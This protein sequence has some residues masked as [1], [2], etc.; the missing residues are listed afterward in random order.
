VARA[1]RAEQ[2]LRQICIETSSPAGNLLGCLS[3]VSK[4][5]RAALAGSPDTAESCAPDCCPD[6]WAC[7]GVAPTETDGASDGAAE[8]IRDWIEWANDAAST[9]GDSDTGPVI[10]ALDELVAALER[11]EQRAARA[12]HFIEC[13]D[14][15]LMRDV[16]AKRDEAV[17]RAERA[18]QAIREHL[19]VTDERVSGRASV[20]GMRVSASV[21]SSFRAVLAGSPDGEAQA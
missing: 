3:A 2:A 1:E 16:L 19:A 15:P 18:E 21:E 4:I 11:A 17:A 6:D 5:A 9:F 13:A 7:G 10:A 14:T 20:Y 8:T 12:E